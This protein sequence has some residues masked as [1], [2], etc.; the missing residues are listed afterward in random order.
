MQRKKLIIITEELQFSIHFKQKV[1]LKQ[2]KCTNTD[3]TIQINSIKLN[4]SDASYELPAL[5]HQ[6]KTKLINNLST[7]FSI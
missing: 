7:V 3:S 1:S 2:I 6:N 5:W 4:I